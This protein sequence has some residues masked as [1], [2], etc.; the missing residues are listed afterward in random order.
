MPH[1]VKALLDNRQDEQAAKRESMVLNGA[2]PV[3]DMTVLQQHAGMS[4]TMQ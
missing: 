1:D 4:L 2:S 3:M